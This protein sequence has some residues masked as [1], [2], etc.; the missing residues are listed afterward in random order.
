MDMSRLCLPLMDP[1]LGLR[2]HSVHLWARRQQSK[3]HAG[4]S[5]ARQAW[6]FVLRAV[7]TQQTGALT[8]EAEFSNTIYNELTLF[9]LQLVSALAVSPYA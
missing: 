8:R 4:R 1:V 2:F 9:I 7:S 5:V 3:L 6:Q